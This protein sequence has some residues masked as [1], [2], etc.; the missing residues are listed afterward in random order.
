MADGDQSEKKKQLFAQQRRAVRWLRIHPWSLSSIGVTVFC[1]SLELL[2]HWHWKLGRF[3]PADERADL[4]GA[5]G[6]MGAAALAIVALVREPSPRLAVVALTLS[7][8]AML[9]YFSG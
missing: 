5:I 3:S 8:L 1:F 4:L 6:T 2:I 7:V 9:P